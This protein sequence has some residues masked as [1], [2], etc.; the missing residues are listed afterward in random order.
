[1]TRRRT[2]K[3]L[4]C[5]ATPR[6]RERRQ[7]PAKFSACQ[8]GRVSSIAKIQESW[9]KL[10]SPPCPAQLRLARVHVPPL[11]DVPGPFLGLLFPECLSDSTLSRRS[12]I[13][14]DTCVC[15]RLLPSARSR[16]EPRR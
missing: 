8:L 11:A 12:S 7:F 1:M 14:R 13:L 16:G 3:P 10:P 5:P 2:N 15:R 9:R 4:S 6:L